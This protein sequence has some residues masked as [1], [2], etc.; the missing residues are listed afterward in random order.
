MDTKITRRNF[1]AG[2]GAI[3][4]GGTAVAGLLSRHDPS[5]KQ[6][7]ELTSDNYRQII[8]SGKPV[9]IDFY[10][11]TCPP[12]R[13]IAPAYDEVAKSY[14]SD[15]VLFTRCKCHIE[16]EN[17]LVTGWDLAGVPKVALVYKG[18]MMKAMRGEELLPMRGENGAVEF[19]K[20]VGSLLS[21]YNLDGSHPERTLERQ[22]QPTQLTELTPENYRDILASE[23]PVFVEFYSDKNPSYGEVDSAYRRSAGLYSADDVLFTKCQVTRDLQHPLIEDWNV[24]RSLRI[25]LAYRGGLMITMKGDEL[26]PMKG[27]NG[28]AGC[29]K[30]VEEALGKY[31]SD[32]AYL[33]K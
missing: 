33:N 30:M 4:L 9:F 17:P 1:I 11:D 18:G 21:H 7:T 15:D 31:C 22:V 24:T 12:C 25:D 23:T 20:I 10:S 28:S 8:D 19:K 32:C 27:E 3:A 29:Q 16:P 5:P 2:L 6:L 13:A 26:L 14:D